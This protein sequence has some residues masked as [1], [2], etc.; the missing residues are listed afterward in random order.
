MKLINLEDLT[1][2]QAK[3]L[4]GMTMYRNGDTHI[5][6]RDKS[7]SID[8]QPDPFC[9]LPPVN[10]PILFSFMEV[11][12]DDG[13]GWYWTCCISTKLNMF[14]NKRK[15]IVLKVGRCDFK[16]KSIPIKDDNP[17]A[18]LGKTYVH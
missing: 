17:F 1:Y 15:V 12:S 6:H 18:H 2:A 3:L 9:P 5:G 8:I 14:T 13:D 4:N 11:E 7:M 16:G 10:K